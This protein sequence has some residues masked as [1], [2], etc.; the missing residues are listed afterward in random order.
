MDLQES[1]EKNHLE[2]YYNLF[3]IDFNQLKEKVMSTDFQNFKE[4]M[5]S[6]SKFIQGT[7]ARIEISK[8]QNK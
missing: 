4:I 1:L 3:N 5:N 6:F 2:N 7:T 8:K